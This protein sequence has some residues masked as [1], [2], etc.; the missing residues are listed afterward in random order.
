[1]DLG[2]YWR[3]F[4]YSTDVLDIGIENVTMRQQ[5]GRNNAVIALRRYTPVPFPVRLRLLLRGNTTQDVS[6]P[7]EVWSRGER[8]EAAVEVKAPVIGARL[9]PEGIVPDWDATN[10]AWGTP[11]PAPATPTATTVG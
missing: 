1:M 8:I 9:W 10:D 7:V 6:M 5:Q 11:V 2:W 3:A 4:W